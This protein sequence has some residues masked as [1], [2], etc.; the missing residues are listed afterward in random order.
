MDLNS[1]VAVLNLLFTGYFTGYPSATMTNETTFITVNQTDTKS[2][3]FEKITLL[4]TSH[5]TGHPSPATMSSKVTFSIPNQ[6]DAN[7]YIYKVRCGHRLNYPVDTS[8]YW[9][10]VLGEDQ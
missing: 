5:F 3:V 9:S 1:T 4:Y 6:T 7:F 2:Y 10:S 8:L